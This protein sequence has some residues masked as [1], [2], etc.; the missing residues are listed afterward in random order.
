MFLDTCSTTAHTC[1][2]T[3]TPSIGR[4]PYTCA[5][6]ALVDAP[7]RGWSPPQP[8]Q[9]P[10]V[11]PSTPYPCST[12]A[13]TGADALT[14]ESTPAGAPQRP[15]TATCHVASSVRRGACLAS[16]CATCNTPRGVQHGRAAC[17]ARYDTLS[18]QDIFYKYVRDNASLEIN[19]NGETKV[20][21]ATL[22]GVT[23]ERGV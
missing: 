21:R 6:Q 2:T 13:R 15:A 12:S 5:R 10:A 9:H 8:S 20:R 17:H 11:L 1:D 3:C 7:T 4:T 22:P 14:R 18:R 23:C 16:W 19:L